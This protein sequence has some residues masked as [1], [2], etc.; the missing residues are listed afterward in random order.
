MPTALGSKGI[1]Q[2]SKCDLHLS[3]LLN[4]SEVALLTFKKLSIS[5]VYLK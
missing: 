3:M 2:P 5:E 4:N 1:I